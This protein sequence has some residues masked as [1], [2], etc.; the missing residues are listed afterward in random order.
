MTEIGDRTFFIAAIMA[1]RYDRTAVLGG[2]LGALVLMT[3]ISG[4]AG[5]AAIALIPKWIVHY[6][7]ISLM[8]FFGVQLIRQGLK[9]NADAGFDE[10]E[11]VEAET[12]K[13]D[14]EEGA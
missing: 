7:V 13:K 11:E 4:V 5:V 14:E 2:A 8:L 10:L 3:V 1:M 6:A 9:L 12:R